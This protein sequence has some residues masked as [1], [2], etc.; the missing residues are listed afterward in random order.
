[1]NTNFLFFLLFLTLNTNAWNAYDKYTC[2]ARACVNSQNIKLYRNFNREQ[3]AQKCNE[4]S[5]CR[6]FEFGMNYRTGSYRTNDCQL[7]SSADT[8]G[9]DGAGHNLDFCTK[10]NYPTCPQD[11][12][13]PTTRNCKCDGTNMCAKNKYCYDQT[14]EDKA[15]QLCTENGVVSVTESCNCSGKVCFV[16]QFCYKG[17]CEQTTMKCDP[18]AVLPMDISCFCEG[19]TTSCEAGKFCHSGACQEAKSTKITSCQQMSNYYGVIH[20]RSFGC[21]PRDWQQYW[22]MNRCMKNPQTSN[23]LGCNICAVDNVTPTS[24]QCECSGD[25][26]PCNAS[27]YCYDKKCHKSKKVCDSNNVEKLE[28]A[29]ECAGTVCSVGKFCYLGNCGKFCETSPEALTESC[30]Y[31]NENS[32]EIKICEANKYFYD[33]TCQD[34][35]PPACIENYFYPINNDCHC[36]QETKLCSADANEYCW[37]GSCTVSGKCTPLDDN[38]AFYGGKVY[39]KWFESERKMGM[40]I[41]TPRQVKITEIDWLKSKTDALKYVDTEAMTNI[42]DWRVYGHC[43][44]CNTG[45][46]S[47]PDTEDY[48]SLVKKG[49][50]FSGDKANWVFSTDGYNDEQNTSKM[51][52]KFKNTGSLQIEVQNKHNSDTIKIQKIDTLVSTVQPGTT[53]TLTLDVKNGNTLSL[54]STAAYININSWTF[55]KTQEAHIDCS[56]FKDKSTCE[57]K[58]NW[59]KDYCKWNTENNI[60]EKDFCKD[61]Y[62][63]DIEQAKYFGPGANYT[64]MGSQMKT[65]L[66]VKAIAHLHK[67][68]NKYDYSYDREMVNVIPV[69]V[70]LEVKRIVKCRFKIITP[71]DGGKAPT[72]FILMTKSEENMAE[73]GRKLVTIVM[74]IFSN[75]CVAHS[76]TSKGVSLTGGNNYLSTTDKTPLTF[77]WDRDANGKV[78]QSYENN[79]CVETLKWEF[80]PAK[81]EDSKYTMQ[82]TFTSADRPS[83]K[84]AADVGIDIEDADVLA[85]VGFD[86]KMATYS[87]RQCKHQEDKFKLG[88]RFWA[89]IE[90]NHL[91]VDAKSIT[92][93]TF[94]IKQ[95]KGD[96]TQETNMMETRYNFL[97]TTAEEDAVNEHTC[98]AELEATHFHKSEAGYDTLL[99][100]NIKIEYVQ[101]HTQT[102]RLLLNV[103]NGM[104]N[105]KSFGEFSVGEAS[106]DDMIDEMYK[107]TARK[108]DTDDLSLSLTLLDM[109]AS[110][111]LETIQTVNSNLNDYAA[112]IMFAAAFCFVFMTMRMQCKTSKNK[113]DND[114]RLLAEEDIE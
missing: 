49:W 64:V 7:N 95:T 73:S 21:A 98:G 30:G 39:G 99:E 23:H 109:D 26:A 17:K 40:S 19:E 66:K 42:K 8:R 43:Y 57:N 36:D 37:D 81:Y 87:D 14:C 1:M 12:L 72:E 91:A 46:H 84:W 38:D 15:K 51:S 94:V 41:T 18:H 79:M 34:S 44:D 96:K 83:H 93:E 74:K 105:K 2:R 55:T 16:G 35:K 101:G 65:N 103:P 104:M 9:C 4:E 45:D 69:L 108:P 60:C 113:V 53:E 77:T 52:Y 75:T 97:Q 70:N 62:V 76:D 3:C 13:N 110:G 56:S 102:R 90:L 68:I 20:G 33:N 32:E 48:D 114:F 88:Q 111:A 78:I 100:S 10:G 27:E 106:S 29:C 59:P 11:G 24:K 85:D 22:G 28:K 5:R 80:V 92:C 82:L 71:Q 31:K 58:D 61:A 6:G 89:K 54:E 25:P 63:L 50:T 86:A 112:Y 107:N 67:S 47:N